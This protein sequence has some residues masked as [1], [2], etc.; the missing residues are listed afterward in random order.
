[1]QKSLTWRT[2][3]YS[4]FI[5]DQPVG[6]KTQLSTKQYQIVQFIVTIERASPFFKY[7][8]VLP[9]VLLAILTLCLYWIPVQSGERFVLGK[10]LF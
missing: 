3:G 6:V 10:W 4:A 8:L 1:M 5:R 9:S 7:V 2:N